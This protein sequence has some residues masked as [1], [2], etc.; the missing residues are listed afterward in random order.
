MREHSYSSKV[1]VGGEPDRIREFEQVENANM[2]WKMPTRRVHWLMGS[3][4]FFFFFVIVK[5]WNICFYLNFSSY[6]SASQP[7]I[8]TQDSDELQKGGHNI[9]IFARSSEDND[10]FKTEQSLRSKNH[11]NW[12]VLQWLVSFLWCWLVSFRPIVCQMNTSVPFKLC[13]FESLPRGFIS[14]TDISTKQETDDF[15][16]VLFCFNGTHGF[17]TARCLTYCLSLFF[18]TVCDFAACM[19]VRLKKKCGDQMF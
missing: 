17:A 5:K 15:C 1:Q 11:L 13:C 12:C 4:W 9:P 19:F 16:F 10:V 2:N 14:Q 18:M 7:H 3:V 6:L 8:V